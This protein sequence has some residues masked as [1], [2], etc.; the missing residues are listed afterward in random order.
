MNRLNTIKI[1][2]EDILS[3]KL[4]LIGNFEIEEKFYVVADDDIQ[5]TYKKKK[6]EKTL[7]KS[8][9]YPRLSSKITFIWLDYF[10]QPSA[11][12]SVCSTESIVFRVLTFTIGKLSVCFYKPTIYA[13]NILAYFDA[14]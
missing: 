3:W 9:S 1:P 5:R 8:A 6:G 2:R 10:A 4:T 14:N 12:D 13:E 11:F 7:I